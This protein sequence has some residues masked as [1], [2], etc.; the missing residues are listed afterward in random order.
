MRAGL[1]DI[2][3]VLVASALQFHNVASVGDA[4]AVLWQAMSKYIGH[5]SHVDFFAD[6]AHSL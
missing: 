6:W 1:Y 2:G 5:E 4:L 3:G